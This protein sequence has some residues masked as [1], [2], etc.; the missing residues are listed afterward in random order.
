MEPF[1]C[2]MQGHENVCLAS[3]RKCHDIGRSFQGP[4]SQVH[5]SRNL[6]AL[7][8][9]GHRFTEAQE[10]ST[11]RSANT[12]TR[13]KK[14]EQRCSTKRQANLSTREKTEEQRHVVNHFYVQALPDIQ[15][16]NVFE[17]LVNCVQAYMIAAVLAPRKTVCFDIMKPYTYIGGWGGCV[18]P[19]NRFRFRLRC[20]ACV[21]EAV[22]NEQ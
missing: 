3:N 20:H 19:G 17:L 15:K 9:P 21:R 10:T 12:S 7:P 4:S 14:A 22:C 18:Q 8:S 16:F 5:L 11:K 2:S 6:R 1:V 13:G